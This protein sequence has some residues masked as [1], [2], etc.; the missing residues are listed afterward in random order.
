VRSACCRA[1]AGRTAAVLSCSALDVCTIAL[2]SYG[3]Q[4]CGHTTWQMLYI[5]ELLYGWYPALM[6]LQ[7]TLIHPSNCATCCCCCYCVSSTCMFPV[8]HQDTPGT[9]R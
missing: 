4:G 2:L 7:T 1:L 3:M 5:N 8:I 6:W 9:S